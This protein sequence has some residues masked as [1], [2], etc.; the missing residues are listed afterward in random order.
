MKAKVACSLLVR[1]FESTFDRMGIKIRGFLRD[2]FQRPSLHPSRNELASLQRAFG[3]DEIAVPK[4]G[5]TRHAYGV[6]DDVGPAPK[7]C[8]GAGSFNVML[9]GKF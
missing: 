8:P 1:C 2:S 9:P 3:A 4:T 5:P 6:D 7:S